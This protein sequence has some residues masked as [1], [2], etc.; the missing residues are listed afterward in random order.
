[1]MRASII[2]TVAAGLFTM[3]LLACAVSSAL[4]LVSLH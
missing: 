4:W 2:G 3:G 1:M